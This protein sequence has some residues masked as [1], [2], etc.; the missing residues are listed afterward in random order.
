MKP[1]RRSPRGLA[2]KLEPCESRV[3]PA[4][5]L[6]GPFAAG[7]RSAFL[8]A[9]L[10]RQGARFQFAPFAFQG[11]LRF[12][13]APFAFGGFNMQRAALLNRPFFAARFDGFVGF[14]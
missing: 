12:R 9:L 10:E 13:S 7:A 2:P 14:G 11:L 4:P 1:S 3:V 6:Q 8:A 5:V